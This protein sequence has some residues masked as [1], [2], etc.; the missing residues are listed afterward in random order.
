MLIKGIMWVKK[1]IKKLFSTLFSREKSKYVSSIFHAAQGNAYVETV[2]NKAD[3]LHRDIK[4]LYEE[5]IRSSYLSLLTQLS[6]HFRKGKVRLG[7][8]Q[9]EIGYYGKENGMYVVGTAYGGKSYKKAFKYISISLLTGKKDERIHLYALPWHIGQD[10][11]ESVETLLSIVKQWFDKIEVIEF[12]RGFYKRELVWWLEENN[13]PYLIHVP[14]QPKSEIATFRSRTKSFYR[15]KYKRKFTMEKTSFWMKT[16]L[17]ICKNIRE[18][19]W[20]FVSSIQFTN[21]WQLFHLYKNRWQIETNYAVNNQNRIMS[22]STNHLIR[23]FYFLCDILI[24]VLWRVSGICCVVFKAFLRL[25]V[26]SV[27]KALEMKPKIYNPEPPPKLKPLLF[28][29]G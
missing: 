19:D 16:T 14:V 1:K 20:T 29:F 26:I 5:D 3:S 17:Y 22:K 27:R 12:D 21:K 23:Y 6:P 2:S 25:F 28:L 13:Y 18:K 15:G 24:Q 11:V 8:D 4:N 7:I 10:M 9:H